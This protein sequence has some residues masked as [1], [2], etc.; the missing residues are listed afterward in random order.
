MLKLKEGESVITV[1][2][3]HWFSIARFAALIIVLL[4]VVPFGVLALP[5]FLPGLNLSIIGPLANFAVAIYAMILLF[6][7]FLFWMFY[8][9]DMWIVTTQR[10]IDIAQEGLFYRQ[11]S[12]IPLANIQNITVE[13]SG[14]FATILGFGTI[15][16]ETAGERDFVMAEVPNFDQLKET[17]LGNADL[18]KRRVLQ[19]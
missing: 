19:H 12:E 5:S 2:H 13:V 9:L 14:V 8:E 17:I 7:L 15:H 4:L 18:A 10:I 1:V 11:V 3:K 6:L 16:V